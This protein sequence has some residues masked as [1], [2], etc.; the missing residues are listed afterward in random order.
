MTVPD[1]VHPDGRVDPLVGLA[2]PGG[3]LVWW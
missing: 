1:V 3:M 2:V